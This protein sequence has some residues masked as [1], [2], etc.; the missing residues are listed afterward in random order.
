MSQ[1]K[2]DAVSALLVPEE[3]PNF[4]KGRPLNSNAILISWNNVPPSRPKEKLLGYGIRYRGL[5]SEL[6]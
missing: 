2:I 4:I 3:A 6:Y 5:V 1:N